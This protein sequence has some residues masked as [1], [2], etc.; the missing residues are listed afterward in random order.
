MKYL[1][2]LIL[3]MITTLNVSAKDKEADK[4]VVYKYK[5]FEK[6]DLE[7]FSVEGETGSPGDISISPRMQQKFYNKLPYRY[8][9]FP[10]IRRS[11]ERTK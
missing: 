9:F 5:K 11:V 2:V 10:E 3:L 6:L 7:D 4:N 8:N 1:I